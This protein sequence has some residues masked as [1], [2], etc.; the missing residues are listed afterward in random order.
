MLFLFDAISPGYSITASNN[1]V[2][3]L[4]VFLSRFRSINT[5]QRPYVMIGYLRYAQCGL[6]AWVVLANFNTLEQL[7]RPFVEFRIVEVFKVGHFIV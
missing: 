3:K 7:R 5:D 6:I 4:V 2:G 1:R